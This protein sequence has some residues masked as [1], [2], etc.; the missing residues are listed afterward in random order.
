MNSVPAKVLS[1]RLSLKFLRA[2]TGGE[3]SEPYAA[4]AMIHFGIGGIV[5][6]VVALL[7]VVV[8]VTVVGTVVKVVD[9]EPRLTVD[10]EVVDVVPD[11]VVL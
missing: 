2:W 4:D 11:V 1:T 9:V 6:T 10:V 5:G 8:L 3:S 7:T